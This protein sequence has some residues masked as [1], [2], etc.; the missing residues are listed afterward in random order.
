[1]TYL[2]DTSAVVSLLRRDESTMARAAGVPLRDQ[3][4]VSFIT[5]G[6]LLWGAYAI[7]SPARMQQELQAVADMMAARV[8]ALL[9]VD[10]IVA[11][12]FAQIGSYLDSRGERISMN[13]T[14]IAA[15]ALVHDMVLVSEDAHFARVPGLKI[16]N[17]AAEPEV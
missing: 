10:A 14:W 3:A 1:M 9:T 16:E 13:D 15:T 12:R 17:W 4:C 2:L 7:R 8:G 11:D 6:E 5:V